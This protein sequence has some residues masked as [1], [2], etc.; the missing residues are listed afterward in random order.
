MSLPKISPADA[1]SVLQWR[2][3]TKVFDPTKSLTADQANALEQSLVLSPS[4]FGLQPWK[5]LVVSNKELRAKI[6]P[7]AWNQSQVTDASHL[8]VLAAKN[9]LDKSDVDRLITATAAGRGVSEESLA[10]Y[11]SVVE[12]FIQSMSPEA[13]LT[14]NK[15]QVY[16]ALGQLMTTAAFLGID[17]CPMEGFE[18]GPV[19]ELL[20]LPSTGYTTAVLCPVGFRDES[21]KYGRAP[22]VRYAPS[23]LLDYRE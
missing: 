17:T 16:I 11:R 19:D 5:F 22:K 14:W 9:I 1:I 4:S 13:L 2:Y 8:Y 20:G 15:L 12:S 3:A 6:R 21:D 23:E 18:R 10:G 7:L